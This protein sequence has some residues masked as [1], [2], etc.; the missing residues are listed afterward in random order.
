[1]NISFLL[2]THCPP[3]S[4][5]SETHRRY[6]LIFIPLGYGELVAKNNFKTKLAGSWVRGAF[7][8][9]CDP[10]FIFATVETS[11]FKFGTQLRFGE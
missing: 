3:L 8:K 7:Q 6:K 1:M 5:S 2:E 4:P 11:N 9:F 10:L